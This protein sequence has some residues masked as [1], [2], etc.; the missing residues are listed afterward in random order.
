MKQW[1]SD[2]ILRTC[3]ANWL[4]YREQIGS[5]EGNFTPAG[6]A[7]FKKEFQLEGIEQEM[8]HSQLTMNCIPRDAP[9]ILRSAV[10]GGIAHWVVQ[11]TLIMD[12]YGRDKTK[13]RRQVAKTTI[14]VMRVPPTVNPKGIAINNVQMSIEP[15][16]ENENNL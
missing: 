5:A 15:E 9:I 4:H 12:Y 11:E 10:V 8:Q 6:W 7:G 16:S 1:A 13:D 3:T 2:T 14:E